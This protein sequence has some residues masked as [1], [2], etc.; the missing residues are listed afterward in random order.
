MPLLIRALRLASFATLVAS[1]S[2][3][4]AQ[5]RITDAPVAGGGEEMF[6][7]PAGFEIELVASEPQVINP[8]TLQLDDKNRLVVSESHTYRYG[9]T[10]TPIK[11]LH[12]PSRPAATARGWPGNFERSWWPTGSKIQ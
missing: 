7:L 4:N 12:K 1:I 6:R 9:P 3:L 5:T 11:P 2:S 10:A 8:V